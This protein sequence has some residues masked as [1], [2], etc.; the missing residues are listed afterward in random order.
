MITC[1]HSF[2]LWTWQIV[3]SKY[4][5]DE[6]PTYSARELSFIDVLNDAARRSQLDPSDPSY[7]TPNQLDVIINTVPADILDKFKQQATP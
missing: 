6:Q 3:A 1:V 7:I 5:V 4:N 2:F